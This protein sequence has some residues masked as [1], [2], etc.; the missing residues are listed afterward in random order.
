MVENVTAFA[1]N[2]LLAREI[3]RLRQLEAKVARGILQEALEERNEEE[4]TR[5]ENRNVWTKSESVRPGEGRRERIE[6][7]RP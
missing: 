5:E 2:F 1:E 7:T 3:S 4:A 6:A